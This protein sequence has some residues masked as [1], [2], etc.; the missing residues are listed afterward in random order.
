MARLPKKVETAEI[1][2]M[3]INTNEVRFN[4][5]GTTPLIMH[6]FD[7]KAWRELLLPSKRKNTAERETTLKHDPIAEFR[8]AIYRSREA[9]APTV[10]HLPCGM[11]HKAIGQAALDIP[12]AAKSQIMRL[13]SVITP[14]VHLYGIPMLGADMV[15]EG[16]SKTPNV[17][18]RPYFREWACEISFRYIADLVQE[19]QIAALLGAAGHIV[20]VG[21][22]RG[23]K[24][25]SFGRFRV[26]EENDIEFRRIVKHQ[27]RA[28]QLEAI[29]HPQYYSDE[30][31]ELIA[32]YF[33]EVDRREKSTTR[34]GS[35]A[36]IQKAKTARA[37]KVA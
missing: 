19:K 1:E 25:G 15:R 22:W 29:E 4:L 12:G 32:W 23:E 21:D 37:K 14:T 28:A 26:A 18:I 5:V 36:A 16:M 2:I 7:Q 13:T 33:E 10:I 3:Q 20:G 9:R 35:E 27:G 30:T 11:L 34:A 8:G 31:K 17:R 24:G 6:R